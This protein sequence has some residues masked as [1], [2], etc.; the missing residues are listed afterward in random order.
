MT[1]HTRNVIE[2]LFIYW[3]LLLLVFTFVYCSIPL[4]KSCIAH[5]VLTRSIQL[6]ALIR[7]VSVLTF[8]K[9]SKQRPFKLRLN[10]TLHSFKLLIRQIVD[11]IKKNLIDVVSFHTIFMISARDS[12]SC[13]H[14]FICTCIR[15]F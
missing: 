7:D 9:Q 6:G 10:I 3:C 13:V 8:F 11:Q 5:V 12:I 15:M 2:N 1:D 14:D 4:K